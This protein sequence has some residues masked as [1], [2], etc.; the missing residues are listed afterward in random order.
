MAS[1]VSANDSALLATLREEF[2]AQPIEE[3]FRIASF[4]DYEAAME[5]LR[6]RKHALATVSRIDARIRRVL[7]SARTRRE[8]SPSTGTDK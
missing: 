4:L 7:E 3:R 1:G 8:R 5:L 2:N 6:E